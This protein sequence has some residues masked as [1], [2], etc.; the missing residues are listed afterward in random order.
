MG[1]TRQ[2]FTILCHYEENNPTP[3]SGPCGPLPHGLRR[4]FCQDPDH[5]TAECTPGLHRPP[6][7]ARPVALHRRQRP[8]PRCNRR[9]PQG[10]EARKL[11]VPRRRQEGR[12]H[13]VR[14]GHRTKDILRSHRRK[15]QGPSGKVPRQGGQVIIK[16]PSKSRG[17]AAF[18]IL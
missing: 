16:L 13:Q 14:Q 12:R 9:L 11:R 17:N 1:M 8:C 5:R 18:F 10:H 7:E 4:A 3:H 15:D 6:H 2:G